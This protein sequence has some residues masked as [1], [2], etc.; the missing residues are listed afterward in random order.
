MVDT[1][2]EEGIDRHIRFNHRVVRAEWSTDDACWRVTA[3]RTDTGETFELA[4]GFL[5]SCSGYYR[6]DRGYLPDF[7]GTDRFGGPIVHPQS[8]PDDL[9]Y[10][11]KRVVVIGSGATAVTLVPALAETASHVTMLQRSPSYIISTPDRNPLVRV[12][13]RILPARRAGSAVRWL[14]ALVTQGFY[15]LS[16]RRPRLVKRMLRAG[17]RRQLPRDFA[18]DPHFTPTYNP[19]DQRMCL[20]P[21]GDLFGAIRSGNASVVTDHIETFTEAGIR[22]TSGA[23]LEADIIVTATGLDLLFI[24]GIELVVDGEVV[25]L[26]S[27]LTYK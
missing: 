15:Q 11:G 20:V 10:A 24:G 4:C 18:I 22:L 14:N 19:W 17:I 8:W 25:D 7:A 2:T 16:R 21:N 27:R 12:L 5:F 6:Y 1:A 9:D 13:R 26:P 3:E 23:E